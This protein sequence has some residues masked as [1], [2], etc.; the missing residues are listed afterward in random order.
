MEKRKKVK[1]SV[2][3][4]GE[5]TGHCHSILEELDVFENSD[6]TREFEV[7]DKATVKHQEH[8]TIV[9]EKP[10]EYVSDK[11]LE[12]DHFAEEARRVQD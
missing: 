9:I 7:K 4:E 3:A 6:G 10:K 2:L 5:V 1:G 11:V 8:G 12:Y